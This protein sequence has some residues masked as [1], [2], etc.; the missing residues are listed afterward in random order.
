VVHAPQLLEATT[1]TCAATP[2]KSL[3][4]HALSFEIRSDP[5]VKFPDDWRVDEEEKE[6]I[7]NLLDGI[8]AEKK[9]AAEKGSAG[10]W[11]LS[12]TDSQI[13]ECKKDP[14][15]FAVCLNA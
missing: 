7:L 13:Q 14:Q 12:L 1:V 4:Q 6:R 10:K 2:Q 15:L 8:A 5:Q 11:Y 9:S 3:Q